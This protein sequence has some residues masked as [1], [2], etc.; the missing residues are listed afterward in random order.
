MNRQTKIGMIGGII[1]FM[2][3]MVWLLSGPSDSTAKVNK[4]KPFVS[5]NWTKRYQINDKNP[6]GLYLFTRLTQSHIDTTNK[7][8]VIADEMSLDSI[9]EMG[10]DPK[11]YMFV[12][13]DFG[14][15]NH[16]ID[17]ILSDVKK[18]SSLFISFYDLTE[19]LYLKLFEEYSFRID[20]DE[21]VNVFMENEKHEMLNLYQNDTVACD[22]WAFGELKFKDDFVGLSSFMEMT[23]FVKVNHGD[24]FVYLHSTPNLFYN[25]QIKR[26]EGFKYA[27]KVLN[28]FPTDND[29]YLLEIGRL[30]DNYGDADTEEK[31]GPDKKED[32]S[33]LQLIFKNPTLLVAMLLSILGVILFLI[34]RSK[35]TRPVVPVIDKKKDMT[36]AFAETI[37]SIYFAKRNPYGLLQVQRKNFFD[38]VNRYFFVDLYKREGDREIRI[39]SEKSNTSIEDIE[40]LIKAFETK[41][42]FNVTEQFV[43]D[44]AKRKHQF[45]RKTGI[46]SDKIHERVVAQEL[47]FSRSLWLPII[48]ILSGLIVFVVGMYYLTAAFGIGIAL[49]PA[50]FI[51]IYLGIARLSNP[52][53]KVT[54][55]TIVY[56]STF[57]GKTIYKRDDL[58]QTEL[59]ETGAVLNFVDNK[60]LIINYWDL[61]R[62]DKRQFERFIS[63]LHT[64]EL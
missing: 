5:S 38:T 7:V 3:L 37:T 9:V 39:L 8:S 62:F 46:I 36:L 30:S 25:Y 11:T 41:K 17:S 12:G 24:G 27:Q 49:W 64:L 53:M 48:F 26:K 16:E 35:R 33:Y 34:F 47:V 2:L 22:W 55:D 29:V 58:I 40:Y 4:A 52:Y 32:T 61:S 23:N 43:A 13:N 21:K 18:G 1:L 20:Y 57:G 51:M 63:K 14:L 10:E 60:K 54:K 59:R 45:Y 42:A 19:N 44:L 31:S 15:Q 6:L 50:S 28:E 56:Y